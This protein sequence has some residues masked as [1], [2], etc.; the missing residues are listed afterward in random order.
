MS[1]KKLNLDLSLNK[2]NTIIVNHRLDNFTNYDITINNFT[3]KNVINIKILGI[4]ID[5][6]LNFNINQKN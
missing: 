6:K 2:T 1:K 4:T 3:V 5:N